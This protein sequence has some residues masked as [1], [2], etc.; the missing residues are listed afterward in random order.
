MTNDRCF[1]GLPAA[2]AIAVVTGIAT[3][4]ALAGCSKP[5]QP[6]RSSVAAGEATLTAAQRQHIHLYA[7]GSSTFRD[8]VDT[9]GVV[10]FDND[11]AT[12]VLAPF[13]GP[14]SRLL[15]SPGQRVGKGE[16]LAFVESSDFSTAVG[17]YRK[18]TATAQTARRL[19]DLDKDL[20]DHQGVSRR[21]ADQAQT[22]AVNAEADRAAASQA[23]SAMGADAPTLRRIQQ[24]GPAARALGVIRS[25]IAGIVVDRPITPGQLL[26]VGV[27][28]CFTVA[29][30]S[31]VWV[32]AQLFSSDL[33]S[34]EVGDTARVQVGGA[35][36]VGRVE[37]IAAQVDPTTGAVA[38]R[39]AV[40]NPGGRLKKQMY[41]RVAIEGRHQSS[42]LLVP[43]SAFLRDE[44]NLP[45]VYLAQPDGG[46]ARRRVTL[47][48]RVGD[49]YNVTEGL[50]PGDRVVVDGGIFVQFM[51][52]Q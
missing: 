36:F 1:P 48:P 15:V 38:A 46:F 51:Q 3:T 14:V 43:A 27:T 41:V 2:L 28:P 44:E 11:Q 34:V 32:M 29:N 10:D 42:G 22:D 31:R 33:S 19:A 50:R 17:A 26:Q 8:M 47:G 12:S 20:L 40:D 4:L 6:A 9:T 13:S 24:G 39:V 37:N 21:E 30:L 7:V 23:L 49:N 35:S 25:P 18:A 45:F 16:A 52:D 5:A